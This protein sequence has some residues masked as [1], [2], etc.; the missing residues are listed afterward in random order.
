MEIYPKYKR[1]KCIT[2]KDKTYPKP[3]FSIK[4][5]SGFG[6][7]NLKGLPAFIE[8][9]NLNYPQID[10]IELIKSGVSELKKNIAI[11]TLDN[12]HNLKRKVKSIT[13]SLEKEKDNQF[14][15]ELAKLFP[16]QISPTAKQKYSPDYFSDKIS[17]FS[18]INL[19][20][21]DEDAIKKVFLNSKLSS[22]TIV[23]TRKALDIIYFE[24]VLKEFKNLLRINKS[25]GLEEKWQ[26]FFTKNPWIFSQIF[27]F[28]ATIVQDKFNVGGKDIDGGTDRIVDYLY[29]NKLSNNIAIIEIKTHK[30]QL[31]NKSPYRKPNIYSISSD[32]TGGIVQVLDQKNQLLKNYN[33]R[34]GKAYRS[35]NSTCVVIAGNTKDF[36]T[37]Y[38]KDSFE[39]FKWSNKD[40]IL[41]PFDEMLVKITDVLKIFKKT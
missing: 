23:S 28:P 5:K 12:F 7:T 27:S 1:I 16:K 32:L 34:I 36:K 29:K 4:V 18:K 24:D 33:S 30:T 40:V 20:K 22:P 41:I 38:E 6:F 10:E 17:Q 2:L 19:S 13:N 31:L 3:G 9:L 37:K 8:Y 35:L 26:S 11:I 21:A 15:N 25:N 14:N 39:L